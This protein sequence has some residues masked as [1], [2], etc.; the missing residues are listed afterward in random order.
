MQLLYLVEAGVPAP[1]ALSHMRTVYREKKDK[2]LFAVVDKMHQNSLEGQKIAENMES[3]FSYEICAI[4]VKAEE[5]GILSEGIKNTVNSLKNSKR[6]LAPLSKMFQ[7]VLYL[8]AALIVISIV[9]HVYLPKIGRY[10]HNWPGLSKM[11]L[12]VGT[13]LYNYFYIVIIAIVLL[14]LWCLHSVRSYTN[15]WYQFPALPF[16]KIYKARLSHFL[17]DT[18]SLL[19][20]SGIG[21]PEIINQMQQ[22]YP[23]GFLSDNLKIMYDRIKSGE[24]NMGTV[25]NTGLFT[26][27]QISEL[28]LI[29]RFVGEDKY[30]EIFDVM[31]TIISAHII[32]SLTRFAVIANI[33]CLI[34]TGASILWIYGAY[35]IL[36][37]SIN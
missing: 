14:F 12:D 5:R 31:S 27:V 13:F 19:S 18:F 36:A 23:K 24:Q 6:F 20:S 29:S 2:V 25:M 30:H 32:E 7:G 22:Q 3:W 35:A 11:L 37:S 16:L 8:I 26:N 15:R 9:G 33:V 28:M 4:L 34:L 1:D 17:L 21:M 10:V